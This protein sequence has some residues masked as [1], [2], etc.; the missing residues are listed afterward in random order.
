[1]ATYKIIRFYKS[2]KPSVV[3][4]T[5]L[6]YKEVFAWCSDPETNSKTA[7]SEEAK[8]HTLMNGDWFD[9][10]EKEPWSPGQ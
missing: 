9:G 1:M 6:S 7:E 3:L 8:R 2:N 4:K 5:G 10:Y